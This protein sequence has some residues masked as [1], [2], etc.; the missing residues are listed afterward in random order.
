MHQNHLLAFLTSTHVVTI[1]TGLL[2][3]GIGGMLNRHTGTHQNIC[4]FPKWNWHH[5]SGLYHTSEKGFITQIKQFNSSASCLQREREREQ[6]NARLPIVIPCGRFTRRAAS[7]LHFASSEVKYRE[8]WPGLRWETGERT[9]TADSNSNI[10]PKRQR[11]HRH[12]QR[13]T[14]ELSI[15]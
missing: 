10:L 13:G 5:G 6:P 14:W 9:E 7:W 2:G 8:N 11:Q 12:Y 1:M 15:F 4:K 3:S